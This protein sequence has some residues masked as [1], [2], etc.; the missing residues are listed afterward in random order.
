MTQ[1]RVVS[2]LLLAITIVGALIMLRVRFARRTAACYRGWKE[3]DRLRRKVVYRLERID[4]WCVGKERRIRYARELLECAIE[5]RDKDPEVS[6]LKRKLAG[7]Y[8]SM[9]PVS[10]PGA[11][12]CQSGFIRKVNGRL[13]SKWYY[14][15]IA[16]S[17]VTLSVLGIDA[18]EQVGCADSIGGFRVVGVCNNKKVEGLMVTRERDLPSLMEYCEKTG[19][20]YDHGIVVL[21]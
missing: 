12:A 14:Y 1:V 4:C 3:I 9:P 11:H 5:S 19:P 2:V 20:W 7:L 21:G 10:R 18:R 6:E 17:L 13:V 16:R 8:E 15:A